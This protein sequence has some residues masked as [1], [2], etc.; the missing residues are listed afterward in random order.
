[1][2]MVNKRGVHKLGRQ[3]PDG[4]PAE[5]TSRFG[6]IT[7]NQYGKEFPVGG[8]NEAGL[9]IELLWLDD[10]RYPAQDSRQT[11]G[12]TQW[13]QYQLDNHS[14]IDEVVK[15]DASVRITSAKGT[16]L[17]HFLVADAKGN[18]A[19][20]EFLHGKMV[21]H[22]GADLPVA[23]IAND[24]YRLSLEHFQA[25]ERG[26]PAK[27]SFQGY[28]F[29]R[30]AKACAIVQ[31]IEKKSS[32]APLSTVTTLQSAFEGLHSIRQV[33]FTKWSVV[34]DIANRQ[35]HVVSSTN[36]ARRSVTV[37]AFSFECRATSYVYDIAQNDAGNV[38]AKFIPYSPTL[39][40]A[41]LNAV[42]AERNLQVVISE[43]AK[44][45]MIRYAETVSCTK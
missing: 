11:L 33:D 7:F 27:G 24:D 3:C 8:M 26:L 29:D 23:A 39:N 16:A 31:R 35:I 30:F 43:S 37:S 1:M 32:Q 13:I 19:M 20:I 10:T 25:K 44:E 4:A 18:V 9:T 14:T 38:T 42:T 36:A 28:S 45:E 21:L 41:L 5:W 12:S 40:G 15:S 34:Y 22:R 6:S 2:L 17:L